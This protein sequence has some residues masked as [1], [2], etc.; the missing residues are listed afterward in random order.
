MRLDDSGVSPFWKND[1]GFR[2][3]ASTTLAFLM[4]PIKS[5]QP[6]SFSFT[7]MEYDEASNIGI[8]SGGALEIE[9]PGP[10]S[11]S[12]TDRFQHMIRVLGLKPHTAKQ[13]KSPGHAIGAADE[14]ES[15]GERVE[16]SIL[17]RR[18]KAH[19]TC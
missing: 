1:N 15:K 9:M 5:H 17:E 4:L 19:D 8:E 14:N 18:T 12:Q 10:L 2:G 16:S 11:Q 3:A 6:I 7:D 13:R